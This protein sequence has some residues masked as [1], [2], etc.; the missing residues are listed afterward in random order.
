MG[1]NVAKSPR[2]QTPPSP[3]R[4]HNNGHVNGS[5]VASTRGKYL[6]CPEMGV[7][8]PYGRFEGARQSPIQQVNVPPVNIRIHRSYGNLTDYFQ[9]RMRQSRPDVRIY[10]RSTGDVCDIS[11][12]DST[13]PSRSSSIPRNLPRARSADRA[14]VSNGAP[15]GLELWKLKTGSLERND[16]ITT[17][18]TTLSSTSAGNCEYILKLSI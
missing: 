5:G 9:E 4:H 6:S 13:T 11:G 7:A 15:R 3:L 18:S 12:N 2:H 8:T 16:R 14:M 10:R 17:P 1:G